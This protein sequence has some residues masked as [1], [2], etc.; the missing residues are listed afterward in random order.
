MQNEIRSIIKK[1]RLELSQ[2]TVK[3]KS[4]K[5]VKSLFS[6]DFL[7]DKQNYFIYKSFKNEVETATI[8][9]R[10]KELNK[11]ISYPITLGDY[12]VAGIPVGKETTT[13]KFGVVIPKNYTVI[14]NVDVAFIPLVACDKN[15]NRIGFGK[16]Y[17]D[18]FLQNKNCIKVGICY[19]FQVVE[20]ITP[21]ATDI[22][23]DIIVTESK[24]I[25]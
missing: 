17:Y 5:V 6:L 19:D 15:K 10:L 21:N 2:E 8:I 4:A 1:Q 22:P 3:T 12:M 18:K 20:S 13:D 24:I 16:G 9:N 11:T 14:E 7:F 23:L 25:K